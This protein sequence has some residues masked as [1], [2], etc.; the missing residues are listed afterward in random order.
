MAVNRSKVPVT[1]NGSI[2]SEHLNSSAKFQ[3]ALSGFP[4]NLV[5]SN[6]TSPAQSP[7]WKSSTRTPTSQAPSSLGSS[8]ATAHKNLPQQH[9]RTQPPMHAQISFG[10][11]Q[12][13]SVANSQ[14]QAPPSN[15]Q[16]GSPTTSSISKGNSGSPR[17]TS[18]ASTNNKMGQA[19]SF[20]AQPPKNSP[21]M[22]P[23]QKS[24]SILGNPHIASSSST[25]GAKTQMQQQSQP[26]TMQ[27][28]QLFFSNPYT[29]SQPPHSTS[30]TS[31]TTAGYYMTQRRPDQHQRAPGAPVTSSSGVLSLGTHT[32]DPATAIAAA[33][34]NVK[35][36]ILSSQGMLQ[37]SPFASQ[38]TGPLLPAGFSYV[39][40]VPAGVQVKP[41][42]Q[43]QPAATT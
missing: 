4:Q 33:T 34:C 18:S 20:S 40:P 3:N 5:Q 43:K 2:Y 23:S 13:Q 26:K 27:Q 31:S 41:V 6:S 24:P 32:N 28:A 37:G 10:G 35:G 11:N 8:P 19:S 22:L 42:E 9:S 15:N 16:V 36:G 30:T 1:S 38:S 17:T 25:S 12:K 7:Q 21:S 14:G 29:Q 39:H